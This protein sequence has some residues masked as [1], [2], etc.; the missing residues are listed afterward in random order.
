[1]ASLRRQGK[2]ESMDLQTSVS[3]TIP[4]IHIRKS[5]TPGRISPL[6]P[7]KQ[8]RQPPSEAAATPLPPPFRPPPPPGERRSSV[9]PQP[10]AISLQHFARAYSKS[11]PL[12]FRVQ[13]GYYGHNMDLELCSGDPYN[14]HCTKQTHIATIQDMQGH[15]YS[16]PMG[17]ALKFS[18]SI[19]PNRRSFEDN[20]LPVPDPGQ[21]FANVSEVLSSKRTPKVLAVTKTSFGGSC[22]SDTVK[23]NEIL[24]VLGV[25][26]PKSSTKKALKVMSMSTKTEKLLTVDCKA[27]FSTESTLVA[28]HLPDILEYLRDMLPCQAFVVLNEDLPSLAHSQPVSGFLSTPVLITGSKVATSLLVSP[29]RKRDKEDMKLVEIPVDDNLQDVEVTVLS[30][31]APDELH[32]LKAQTIALLASFNPMNTKLL[33]DEPSS[34]IYTTQLMLY[35]TIKPGSESLGVRFETSI[36]DDVITPQ[37][38]SQEDP[39]IEESLNTVL[40]ADEIE[41]VYESLHDYE[42]GEF[43]AENQGRLPFNWRQLQAR[44]RYQIPL[45]PTTPSLAG[46]V[47]PS[48]AST[49]ASRLRMGRCAKSVDTLAFSHAQGSVQRSSSLRPPDPASFLEAQSRRF[50]SAGR[51]APHLDPDIGFKPSALS[52]RQ[53]QV[54][55]K[56]APTTGLK[57]EENTTSDPAYLSPIVSDKTFQFSRNHKTIEN[58]DDVVSSM[59]SRLKPVDRQVSTLLSSMQKKWD[60]AIAEVK[61]ELKAVKEELM[62]VRTKFEATLPS[63]PG[64]TVK[65]GSGAEEEVEVRN[66]LFVKSLS[67]TQVSQCQAR[68]T[69]DFLISEYNNRETLEVTDLLRKTIEIGWYKYE[70]I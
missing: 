45:P 28:M 36:L 23:E 10:T 56:M 29:A 26:K 54:Q 64:E 47:R 39:D 8:H 24:I 7:Q 25:H 66:K 38:Q 19:Q 11:F 62:A 22:D 52:P 4:D 14:A 42:Q 17:S 50:E 3:A 9:S 35:S 59:Y 18:L 60:E 12:R 30:C 51:I 20:V 6:S 44:R 32:A 55:G 2:V 31:L 41:N 27:S 34:R 15:T 43:L 53:R 67:T 33:T 61:A 48:S 58:Q 49:V 13:Q 40:T 37:G 5:P 57:H 68:N 63:T 70:C 69:F 65:T 46:P 21:E 16:V 1:M